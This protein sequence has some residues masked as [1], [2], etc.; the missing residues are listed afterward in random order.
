MAKWIT[1]L[2]F[3]FCVATASA[4]ETGNPIKAK[5]S[6]DASE[7]TLADTTQPNPEDMKIIAVLEILNSYFISANFCKY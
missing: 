2:I 3:C 1:W 7:K 6:E 5:P 4:Q